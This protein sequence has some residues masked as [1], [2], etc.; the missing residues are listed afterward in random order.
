LKVL[1]GAAQKAE[2]YIGG[3]LPESL[4]WLVKPLPGLG[5]K[6]PDVTPY[7]DAAADHMVNRYGSM[8]NALNTLEKDPVGVLVDLASITTGFGQATKIPAITKAGAAANPI[9]LAVNTGKA[10]A[11]KLIPESVPRSM[12]ESVAKFSTTLPEKK[13]AAMVDTALKHEL[14]P[15]A[16]GVGKLEGMVSGLNAKLDDLIAKATADGTTIPAEAVYKH[17]KGLRQKKGGMSMDAPGDL[18]SI[19]KIIGTFQKHLKDKGKSRLTAAELQELKVRTYESINWDAKRMTGS[20]IKEDT[21]KVVARGAKE[22]VEQIVP[23]VKGVNQQLGELYELQPH[24]SRAASRVENKN[25]LSVNDAPLV[26]AG[27]ISGGPVG[28]AIGSIVAI[29]G[30]DKIKGALA[31]KL[32][33]MIQQPAFVKFIENNPNISQAQLL[34]IIAGREPTGSD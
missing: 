5:N 13:R 1:G 28:T 10:V 6:A 7:I 15:T 31:I 23:D 9:N 8:D 21:Y 11:G 4:Q 19:N 16:K 26:G 18:E 12:Y 33:K 24:L 14:P 20:P 27:T 29:L 32:N 25:L 22:G 2:Q 30:K 34:G 17:L 3:K